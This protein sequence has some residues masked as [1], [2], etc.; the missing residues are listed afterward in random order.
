MFLHFVNLPSTLLRIESGRYLWYINQEYSNCIV[1]LFF[2]FKLRMV[3]AQKFFDEICYKSEFY[4]SFAN[5]EANQ[6]NNLEVDF[7]CLIHFS[8][9]VYPA[10]YESLYNQM[11]GYCRLTCLQISKQRAFSQS[12]D[13]VTLPQLVDISGGSECPLLKYVLSP[14][15]QQRKAMYY[16]Q[17]HVAITTPPP[18]IY[19]PKQVVH[20]IPSQQPAFSVIPQQPTTVVVQPPYIPPSVIP[21]VSQVPQQTYYQPPVQVYVNHSQPI[22]TYSN[23]PSYSAP[24]QTISNQTI[25]YT[26]QRPSSSGNVWSPQRS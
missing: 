11:R 14:Q 23:P 10:Q 18:I 15:E 13:G 25:H 22:V 19:K 21:Q 8:L 7:L 24:Q 2:S 12:I 6:M 5:L 16:Q 3:L 26:Y 17:H 20:Y 9:M 1:S 4:G